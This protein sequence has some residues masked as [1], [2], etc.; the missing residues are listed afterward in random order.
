MSLLFFI[1]HHLVICLIVSSDFI[2]FFLVGFLLIDCTSFELCCAFLMGGFL[3]IDCTSF[4][5]CFVFFLT[6]DN[7]F[8]SNFV[9]YKSSYFL[10]VELKAMFISVVYLLDIMSVSRVIRNVIGRKVIDMIDYY[11]MFCYSHIC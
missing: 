2:S 3:L 8:K 11:K 1:T 4:K 7:R 6:F 5:L 9:L 10:Y